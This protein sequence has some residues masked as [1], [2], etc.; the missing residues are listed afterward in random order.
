S[1]VIPDLIEEGR[2]RN[3]E[4][5]I[6]TAGCATGEE[7][8][9]IALLLCEMLGDEL[10]SFNVRIFGTDLDPDAIEF[11]RH[12]VYPATA[13][14]GVPAEIVDRFMVA[15]DSGYE[16]SKT[17]RSLI[18]FG[19]HDLGQRAPFPRIDLTLCRNV[20]IYFTSEL[21]RRALQIFAFSLRDGGY[22]VLGKSETTSPLPD[23]FETEQ[24]TLRVFRRH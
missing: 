12:G 4:I 21:Q 1:N 22:L 3:N 6:W 2:K 16:M 24:L 8:Y 20:L 5:R 13:L 15:R 17:V 11:A 10:D 14:S 23:L 19:Q 18:I 9:S 7:A